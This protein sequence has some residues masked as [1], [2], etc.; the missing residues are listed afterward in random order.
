MRGTEERAGRRSSARAQ[1]LE[2]LT[3][4]DERRLIRDAIE[5]NTIDKLPDAAPIKVPARLRRGRKGVSELANSP[6]RLRK[7]ARDLRDEWG[8]GR[9]ALVNAAS[10]SA[11][12]RSARPSRSPR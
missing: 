3:T 1:A 6:D 7:I 12:S 4:A 10:R 8:A 11:R 2:T 9:E 5:N